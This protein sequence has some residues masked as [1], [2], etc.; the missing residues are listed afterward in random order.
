MSSINPMMFEIRPEEDEIR[1]IA[2]FDRFKALAKNLGATVIIQ[3][4]SRDVG[5][6]Q[7]LAGVREFPARVK[8]ATLAWHT[9]HNALAGE[10]ETAHTE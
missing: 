2:S 6:L 5:K 1:S 4:E 10:H 9:L 3:H 7:V 8:C